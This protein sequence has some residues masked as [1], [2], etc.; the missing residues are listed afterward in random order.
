MTREET[1]QAELIYSEVPVGKLLR[2]L[3]WMCKTAVQI[4]DHDAAMQAANL[5]CT[6]EK[7]MV[8]A[9]LVDSEVR[10]EAVE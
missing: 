9:G 4:N 3:N 2:V 1:K 8:F 5:S 6:V 7:A 10:V